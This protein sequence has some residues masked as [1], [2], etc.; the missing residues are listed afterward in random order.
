MVQALPAG[1]IL[2]LSEC[3]SLV[4]VRVFRTCVAEGLGRG[5]CNHFMPLHRGA[6]ETSG[7]DSDP[8]CT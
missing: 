3:E 6:R 5:E 8:T 4:N 7:T 1:T 2:T